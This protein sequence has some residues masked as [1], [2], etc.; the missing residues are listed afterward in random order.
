[1]ILPG[2][3]QC[4][5]VLVVLQGAA[6]PAKPLRNLTAE[7]RREDPRLEQRV[8][9]S[10]A[11]IQV[12]D[13]LERLAKQTGVPV[14]ADERSGASDP[15]VTVYLRDLPLGDAL[16]ALWSLV[17]YKD[18]EWW[19]EREGKPGAYEYVLTR[20]LS[21]QRL[22]QRLRDRFQ[23]E[24]EAEAE[25]Y[26]AAQALTPEQQ[27]ELAKKD[28]RIA[29]M[30]SSPRA[31]TGQS[32][33]FESLSLEQQRA[34]LR[35]EQQIQVPLDK[36]G[37]KGKAL[38]KMVWDEGAHLRIDPLTGDTS[39][40]P[41][42]DSVTFGRSWSER[43]V[44]PSLVIDIP[45]AGG[46]G[47][48][49][50]MPLIRSALAYLGGLWLLD[51]DARTDA[52]ESR[53]LDA[54]KA[55][56]VDLG[57]QE[58]RGIDARLRRLSKLADVSIIA[59]VPEMQYSLQTMEAAREERTLAD[60]LYNLRNNAYR[61]DAK[62]RGRALL[63]AVPGWYTTAADDAP[64]SFTRRLRQSAGRDGGFLGLDDLAEA[65][66]K[67]SDAQIKLL[68]R[69]F[70][71]LDPV[72]NYRWLLASIARNSN[73]RNDLQS[74]RGAGLGDLLPGGATYDVMTKQAIAKG[75][76]YVRLRVKT[77]VTERRFWFTYLKRDGTAVAMI[78]ATCPPHVTPGKAAEA[79]G[80]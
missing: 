17:S 39:P 35:G 71:V 70:P 7:M 15:E 30:V 51:G 80:K 29:N 28:P 10:A 58:E 54:K 11:R 73:M 76:E 34:V 55:G 72:P 26:R 4:C 27:K 2:L 21:A 45:G 31:A 6:T 20:P 43:I 65:A 23:A 49:G 32:A 18:A 46:Y 9:L 75:A 57:A 37:A 36:L 78:G 1:M 38:V 62:W 50:G 68:T 69:E 40:E 13:V 25:A 19:W 14:R 64:W 56:T 5:A 53:A 47:Y 41:Y 63:L 24:F 48:M 16:D 22:P 67:L 79:P 8:T 77:T 52:T 12:G 33:F 61:F 3:L 44:S 42:P 74:K 59:R 66:E 60:T